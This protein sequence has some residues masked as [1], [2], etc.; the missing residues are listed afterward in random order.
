M[1]ASRTTPA[2]VEP[3][4]MTSTSVSRDATT[5]G[6][7]SGAVTRVRSARRK[8]RTNG[9]GRGQ[10]QARGR[11]RRGDRGSRAVPRGREEG[12]LRRGDRGSRAVP[13]GREEGRLRRGDRGSRA[14]PRGREEGRLRRGDRGGGLGLEGP[15]A[16]R[17]RA[18][19]C[20]VYSTQSKVRVTAFFQSPY[21]LSRSAASI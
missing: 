3:P 6:G 14:P 9:T 4:P 20:L 7:S 1:A 11:L 12:R 17:R 2:P 18:S 21:S 5:R 16:S 19:R 8:R 15:A 13:R 10:A